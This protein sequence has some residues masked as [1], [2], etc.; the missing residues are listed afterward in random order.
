MSCESTKIFPLYL[1]GNNNT[2]NNHLTGSIPLELENNNFENVLFCN[3]SGNN[4]YSNTDDAGKC[5]I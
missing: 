1:H 5:S 2:D 3:L 4:G